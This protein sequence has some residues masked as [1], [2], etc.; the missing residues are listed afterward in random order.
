MAVAAVAAA[1]AI[2]GAIGKINDAKRRQQ[3]A[4]A[5]QLLTNDQKIEL[6]NRLLKATTQA[7]RLAIVTDGITEFR[8]ANER[9]AAAKKV[10]LLMIAGGL[11]LVLLTIATIYYLKKD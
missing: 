6:S 3:F 5:L 8:S 9:A 11:G 4:N 7:D 1:S 2:M 10:M